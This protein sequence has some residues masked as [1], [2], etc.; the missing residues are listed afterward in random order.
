MRRHEHAPGHVRETAL[1]AFDAWLSWK[2]GESTRDGLELH[3]H[4]A[5]WAL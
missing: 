2:D 5:R 4:Y 1:A 3:R